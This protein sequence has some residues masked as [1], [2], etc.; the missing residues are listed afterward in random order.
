[1]N[2]A[3]ESTRPAPEPKPT[4]ET[5]VFPAFL[6]KT[7]VLLGS[8]A[9]RFPSRRVFIVATRFSSCRNEGTGTLKNVRPQW[10]M[11][12][13]ENATHRHALLL[14]CGDAIFIVSG[15]PCGDAIFIVSKPGHRHVEKRAATRKTCGHKKN[16]RPQERRATTRKPCGHSGTP[17]T[18]ASCGVR[19]SRAASS[20]SVAR[21]P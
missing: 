19:P 10:D 7:S 8:V 17:L 4:F 5:S 6:Q 20:A 16:V 14:N 1:M 13:R 9:T 11:T 2:R 15:L 18:R 12:P 21:R 3:P